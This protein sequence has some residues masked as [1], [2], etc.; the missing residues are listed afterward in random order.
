VAVTVG[1]RELRAS[2]RSYLDRVRG[3]EEVVVTERGKPVARLVPNVSRR[4]QLIAEG[5][6]R[7]PL[8]PKT[9]IDRSKLPKARESVVD[10]LIEHRGSEPLR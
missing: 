3:G 9:P 8:R 2:L 5:K 10:M 1:V 7:P 6:I 4:E